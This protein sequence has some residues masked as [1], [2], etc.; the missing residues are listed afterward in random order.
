MSLEKNDR[1]QWVE[2]DKLK[3]NPKNNNEHSDEQIERLAEIIDYQG[4]RSPIVVS[5]RTG[6][7]V[8]GHGRLEAAKKLNH[9]KVPVSY[10]DFEDETQEFAHMTADNAIASWAKLD[11]KSVKDFA[12][13]LDSTFNKDLFG[14]QDLSFATID[15]EMGTEDDQGSLDTK[16]LTECPNCLEVFDHAK[17]KA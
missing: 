17:N 8:A 3:P 7:I 15:F 4:F 13:G 12:A 1:L 6:F 16:T 5:N 14:V 11:V 10:Q 2:I 9:T